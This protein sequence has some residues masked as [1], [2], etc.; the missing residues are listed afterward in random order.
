MKTFSCACGASLYFDNTWCL[1]CNSSVG[2]DPLGD[3]M[4]RLDKNAPWKLCQN[5]T[6]HR[7][8]NWV[9]PIRM[10]G[11]CI[12]CQINRTIPDL[13]VEQNLNLWRKMEKAKRR[14][15]YWLIR[16][17]LPVRSKTAAADTGLAVDFLR[18]TATQAV[19]TG[20]DHGVL[21]F[22]L[23]E[24]DDSHRESHRN[25]LGEPYR[26]L[27][28]HFRHEMAHYYWWL[29]FD[30]GGAPE[31][32]INAVREVFGDDRRDYITALQTHYK[33]GAP[34]GWSATHISAYATTHPWEDWAETWAHYCLI[35]DAL[36]TAEC[37]R[38]KIEASGAPWPLKPQD[39]QL[40]PP[41]ASESGTDFLTTIHR[42]MTLAP[43]LN[44]MSLSL[45]HADMYPFSP[46][47][48]VVKKLHL[49]HA[50][51]ASRRPN[52]L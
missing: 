45:G 8:C 2:Y 18:P 16:K 41:F 14:T 31:T 29:W 9:I 28:G 12:A 24:A 38:L 23:E 3:A 7:V 10:T 19:L 47:P 46:T 6:T 40:P 22:N 37:S 51:L 34:A 42:W 49:I 17:N 4:V 50:M 36:E 48:A 26:T 13:A 39:V 21:T 44:E 15:V 1:N 52:L 25:L 11:L 30:K 43:A 35:S 27:L 32:W 33:S 20:H 5:G